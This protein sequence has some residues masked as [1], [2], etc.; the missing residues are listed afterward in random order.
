[1]IYRVT[2]RNVAEQASIRSLGFL[3]RKAEHAEKQ[4]APTAYMTGSYYNN[5]QTVL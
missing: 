4:Q 2:V 1:M 5:I 3:R